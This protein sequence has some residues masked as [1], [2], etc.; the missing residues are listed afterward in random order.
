MEHMTKIKEHKNYLI[1][2]LRHK[3][4]VYKLGRKMG[5][6]RW[7]LLVH[8]LS[9]F[10]PD[11]WFGYVSWKNKQWA[12]EDGG[13]LKNDRGFGWP[14]FIHM[15]RNAHHWQFWIYTD[16]SGQTYPVEIPIEYAVEMIVDWASAGIVR[17]GAPGTRKYYEI[18]KDQILLHEKTRDFVNGY[19]IDQVERI[20]DK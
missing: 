12:E 6:G 10:L 18:N 3:Y 5:L 9:K 15:K 17:F 8:D 2:L 11:E 1:F 19:A 16:D 20:A 7:K 14:W 4:W 13:G